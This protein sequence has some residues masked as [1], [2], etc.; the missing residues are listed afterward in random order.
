MRNSP[1]S[2]LPPPPLCTQR[3]R[4]PSIADDT[5]RTGTS[6][7][8]SPFAVI[9]PA[10]TPSG[11]S[12]NTTAGASGPTVNIGGDHP[13]CRCNSPSLK[14][15]GFRT[16]SA[17]CC[18]ASPENSKCSSAPVSADK[19]CAPNISTSARATPS[20]LTALTTVPLSVY[21]F[22][23]ELSE[24]PESCPRSSPTG[25]KS[26]TKIKRERRRPRRREHPRRRPPGT[27]PAHRPPVEISKPT[28]DSF[29]PSDALPLAPSC[30]LSPGM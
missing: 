9:R 10:I 24:D 19:C 23:P 21:L 3:L 18:A 1:S 29:E 20:P 12:F 5:T 22:V 30:Q 4:P 28:A 7:T 16:P 17:V 2:S 6:S 27:R 13:L 11:T 25:K 26:V 15:P 8:G 14:N